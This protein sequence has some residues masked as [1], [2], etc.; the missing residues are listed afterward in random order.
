MMMTDG[1]RGG[2]DGCV[3]ARLKE[4]E[5]KLSISQSRSAWVCGLQ[6]TIRQS[7]E[8][9]ARRHMQFLI[10]ARQDY[11]RRPR[12]WGPGAWDAVTQECHLECGNPSVWQKSMGEQGK[13]GEEDEREDEEEDA[14]FPGWEAA[15]CCFRQAVARGYSRLLGVD[16]GGQGWR[17]VTT[18]MRPEERAASLSLLLAL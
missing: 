8:T 1:G 18:L 3:C 5:R 17:G 9:R 4:R 16:E 12:G 14:F 6:M 2:I 11:V 15:C 10:S 13:V 7:R